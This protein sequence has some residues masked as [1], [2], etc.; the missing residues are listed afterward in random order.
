MDTWDLLT[1]TYRPTLIP[2][3]SLPETNDAPH[4]FLD[5]IHP[6]RE[7][8][9]VNGPTQESI[10]LPPITMSSEPK[11]KVLKDLITANNKMSLRPIKEPSLPDVL[12][13]KKTLILTLGKCH[14]DDSDAGY[15]YIVEQLS[16]FQTR[17]KNPNAILPLRPEQPIKPT[18]SR[19]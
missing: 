17:S 13:F 18:D 5:R 14:H 8:P 10:S 7:L 15:S 19:A 12:A 6:V 4:N 9:I 1:P 3:S 11:F 2:V 16:D